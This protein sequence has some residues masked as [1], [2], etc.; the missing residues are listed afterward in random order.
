[1]RST[2]MVIQPCNALSRMEDL[3]NGFAEY[4]RYDAL[5]L[6]GLIRKKE[7]TPEELC[8]EAIGRVERINPKITAVIHPMFDIARDLATGKLPDGPFAGVPLNPIRSPKLEEV[9][10]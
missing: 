6:A 1:M 2:N 4:D 5:V 9:S 3:V 7:I 10:P 8:E